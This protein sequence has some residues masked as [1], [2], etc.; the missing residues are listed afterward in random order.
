MVPDGNRIEFATPIYANTPVFSFHYQSELRG[1]G[2]GIRRDWRR[3]GSRR[4]VPFASRRLVAAGVHGVDR[5]TV[6]VGI[7][8][9]IQVGIAGDEPPHLRVVEPAPHQRQP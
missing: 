9:L 4:L 3:L 6:A 5:I 2:D 8:G 7:G 1:P